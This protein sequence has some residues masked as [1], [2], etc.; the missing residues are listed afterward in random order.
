MSDKSEIL[1]NSLTLIGSIVAIISGTISIIG[2]ISW[3]IY[4]PLF[5]TSAVLLIIYFN[6][7]NKYSNWVILDFNEEVDLSDLSN[8]TAVYRL[9]CLL[10]SLKKRNQNLDLILQSDGKIENAEIS[11]GTI[12]NI[13]TE[14]GKYIYSLLFPQVVDKGRNHNMVF[15]CDILNAFNQDKG[16]WEI[17]RFSKSS[18]ITSTIL[19]P[20]NKPPKSISCFKMLGHNKILTDKQP[21]LTAVNGKLALIMDIKV[22]KPLEK[23]RIEW[24]W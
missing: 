18:N 24:F 16:Y 4:I 19:F 22:M 20:V 6:K 7:K 14:G 15:K 23:Y 3:Y 12:E 13:T 17:N 1:R 8:K 11:R 21:K 2:D 5:L 9:Q 10:K